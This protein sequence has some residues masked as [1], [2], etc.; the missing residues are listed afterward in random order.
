MRPFKVA[1][2]ETSESAKAIPG[3]VREELE[4]EGIDFVVRGCDSRADLQAFAS[5][6]HLV[7]VWGSH[8]LTA[9]RLRVLEKCGAILRSGSG[10]DNVPVSEATKQR[11]LVV[12]TPGAVAQE[13]SDHAIAMLLAVVRQIVAQD[14]RVRTG[15]WEFHRENNRWHLRGS[16]LGL[17]G[18][19]HIAQLV[20]EKTK[21]FG[22]RTLVH[23][24]W[25]PTDTI[26]SRGAE[27]V[28]FRTLL[29]QSDFI[30]VHCPLTE[31]TRH[32]IGEKEIG[33]MKAHAILINT[34][35]GPIVDEA[36]L[37]RA[38]QEKRIGAAGLDVFEDEPLPVSSPLLKLENVILTPHIAGY[39]DVFPGSF[40]RYS[41]ESAIAIANGY[42]PR[43]VVNPNVEPRWPL[44][45]RQW[46]PE[47]EIYKTREEE[48]AI[49][50][51]GSAP[52]GTLRDDT[53]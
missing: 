29:S 28:A 52:D 30:T 53:G 7:W 8:V 3:W 20:A 50:D 42:W 31:A 47:V 23:D 21:G 49:S 18:F 39:S 43:S 33:L 32:L 15:V 9:D 22:V 26:R 51:S 4:A 11:M 48:A 36:A 46:P 25:V 1:L 27:P 10:T 17:I 6:S 5:D 40:W 12:N 45:R 38:L 2:V 34:S 37:A 16:T 35:R 14:R 41:V 13:V 24:P 19:G 44:R